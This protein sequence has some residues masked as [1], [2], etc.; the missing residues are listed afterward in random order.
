MKWSYK[1][2]EFAGIGVYVHATF[3][4]LLAFVAI[5][6]LIQGAGTT[7]ALAAVAFI[8]TLFV[9]VVAHEY[10]HAL[11]ARRFGIQTKEITLLPIGGVARLERMPRE[12]MQELWIALAGPAVNV[13]IAAILLAW[14]LVADWW[15][16]LHE[17]GIMGADAFVERLLMVNLF[18]V[19]F[20][21]LPAFPMDGGRVL[22][23]LM[24]TRMDYTR[25]TL[26]AASIGQ[27][28]AIGFAF[29]GLFTNPLLLLIAFFVWVGAGQEAAQ[30]QMRTVMAD[31]PV[32]RAMITQ[33]STLQPGDTLAKAVELILSG[34]QQDFPVVMGDEVVG[35][36]TRQDLLTALARMPQD[37]P[38]SEVMHREFRQVEESETL[39]SAFTKLQECACHTMPV[40]SNG[41]LV[42]LLTMENVGEFVMIQTALSAS[43]QPA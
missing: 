30:V 13:L 37:T 6:F 2:A 42:G 38:V 43:R 10:G 31:I 32:S 33:F 35:I 8:L 1:I 4:V 25:A 39:E 36:L 34:T 24:A 3:F 40:T 17:V 11:A 12:P 18:L 9:C 7:A 5:A 23:A 19:F 28:M 41:R 20:N 26:L 21:M 22:R 16:P 27:A 14:L 29:L 15:R